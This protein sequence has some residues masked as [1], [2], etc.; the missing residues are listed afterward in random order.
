MDAATLLDLSRSDLC[1]K[2]TLFQLGIHI[3]AFRFVPLAPLMCRCCLFVSLLCLPVWLAYF[4]C[5][6]VL[7]S[8]LLCLHTLFCLFCL[9]AHLLFTCFRLSVLFVFRSAIELQLSAALPLRV[10]FYLQN[11]ILQIHYWRC[12]RSPG[13]FDLQNVAEGA[14]IHSFVWLCVVCV[15]V[16]LLAAVVVQDDLRRMRGG[17]RGRG[18]G[19]LFFACLFVFAYLSQ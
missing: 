7:M 17:G 18:G 13:F 6:C 2:F 4:V 9:T 10:L 19:G 1:T 14:F 3:C 16:C 8:A 12:I 5:L 15:F 11:G